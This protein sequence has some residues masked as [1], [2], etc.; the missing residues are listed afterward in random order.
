MAALTD[1]TQGIA[2]TPFDG[3]DRWPLLGRLLHR[4]RLRKL[5]K[6]QWDLNVPRLLELQRKATGIS[7][8]TLVCHKDTWGVVAARSRLPEPPKP[9]VDEKTGMAKVTLSGPVLVEVLQSTLTNSI[10][11]TYQRVSLIAGRVYE[12]LAQVIEGVG[13]GD[14]DGTSI[15]DVVIDAKLIPPSAEQRDP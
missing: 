11:S 1:K 5:Q 3:K 10:Y 8:L 7:S 9:V 6:K 2:R 13:S 4:R 15:P 14:E 12:E